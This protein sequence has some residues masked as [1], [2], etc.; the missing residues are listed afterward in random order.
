M[1]R[2]GGFVK[3]IDRY[4]PEHAEF[5]RRRF[6][7]RRAA[8]RLRH[9][10][11][12]R[13]PRQ[14]DAGAFGL[15]GGRL[16]LRSAHRGDAALAARDALGGF[17]QIADRALAADRAV[18]GVLGFDAETLGERNFR[19]AV[20]PAQEI[21]DVER[22]D[23]AQQLGAA[24]RFGT[25]QRLFQ[26]DEGLEAFG[27]VPGAVHDFSDADDDGDAVV[28]N[29]GGWVFHSFLFSLSQQGGPHPEERPLGRV[30]KDG[31]NKRTRCHPSRRALS[32]L[33]RM[34]SEIHSEIP[35]HEDRPTPP[36]ARSCARPPRRNPP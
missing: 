36:S 26:Q 31:R 29:G 28:G 20:A 13:R 7:E 22:G 9:L 14:F 5:D 3:R 33:L 11:R 2:A 15:G 17:V 23:L 8:L 19:I 30:S 35:R 1:R 16:R 24:V 6:L 12:E 18:I 32:A 4:R 10:V 34:S 27:D 25:P 21:D